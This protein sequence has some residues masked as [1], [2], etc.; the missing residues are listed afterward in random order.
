MGQQMEC[1]EN[2]SNE[3]M[4]YSQPHVRSETGP[5]GQTSVSVLRE[6]HELFTAIYAPDGPGHLT[7]GG[8]LVRDCQRL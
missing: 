8:R 2:A 6:E 7:I 4:T 5:Q 3:G 1:V